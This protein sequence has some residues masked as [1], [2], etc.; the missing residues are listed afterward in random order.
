MDGR[1]GLHEI[2]SSGEASHQVQ[3][4]LGSQPPAW[5]LLPPPT[6]ADAKG[7]VL[8]LLEF[9]KLKILYTAAQVLKALQDMGH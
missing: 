8:L 6:K 1:A 7:P 2:V 3:L 4:L 5:W 9:V